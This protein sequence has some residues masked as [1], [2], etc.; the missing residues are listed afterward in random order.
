MTDMNASLIEKRDSLLDILRGYGSVAVAFS[1]GIDS[2]VVA[3]AAS[4]SLGPRA[5]AVTAVSPS[6]PHGER[7]EA[8]RLARHIGIAHRFIDTHEFAVADY[9]ANPSNRCYFCKTELYEQLERLLPELGV[10]LIANGANLD[11]TGDWRPGM[12]AAHEH[13]VRSPLV[14]A[15]LAKADVRELARFW[16]LPTWDKPASPCLSSRI[17][18]GLEVTPERVQMI[19]EAERFLKQRGMRELRVRLPQPDVARIEVPVADLPRLVQPELRD[20][21][22]RHF[23]RLGF[24][25]VTLDLEGF[26][27][28]SLNTVLPIE[29]LRLPVGQGTGL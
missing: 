19:D 13:R 5:I 29:L 18:Y 21:I 8:E 4:L 1:A 2:T 6:L 3:K 24:K 9:T 11:D 12:R 17:A 22:V 15:R 25:F 10:E 28:G 16:E 27:S 26:R 20:A 14:E 7:D 23:R